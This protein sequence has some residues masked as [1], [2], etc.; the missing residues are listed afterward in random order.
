MKITNYDNDKDKPKDRHY[1]D[2]IGEDYRLLISGKSNCGK[3]NTMIHIIRKPLVYYDKIY[4]YTP[5]GHQSKLQDL[6]KLMESINKKLKYKHP[7]LE[8]LT[9]DEIKNTNEYPNYSRIMVVSDDLINAPDAT[10]KKI[11]NHFTDGRHH[12]ISPIF[13]SQSYYDTPKKIRINCSHMILYPSTDKR[14]CKAVADD[15]KVNIELCDCLKQYEFLFI[16][17]V[18]KTVKK[19]F[20]LSI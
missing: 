2:F 1:Y 8:I 19:N 18:N 16:D 15:N 3:T 12:N 17:K 20:D 10:Q 6:S 14:D 11:A 7:A 5:N 13:L 9:E 4:I